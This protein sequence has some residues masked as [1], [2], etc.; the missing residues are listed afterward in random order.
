LFIT[1]KKLPHYFQAYTMIVLTSLPL[2]ALFRSS[3]FSGRISKWGAHLG[4]YDVRYR[5]RTSIKGQVLAD[6]VAKFAPEHSELPTME[7]HPRS[8]E[9]I[10]EKSWWTLYVDGAANSRGSGLGIVLM[11]PGGEMV[12]Q[13]V[14][15]GFGASNNEAE[16]EALLHGLRAAKRLGASFLNIRCDSQLI[17]NQLT[18][19]YMAKDER[20]MAYRD[21]AKGL[22][23]TFF[24][25]NIER[26]GREHNGHADS[27]AGI[28]SSVAPDFRR[29][30]TVEVQDSP[31][32]MKNSPAIICQI[33]TGP[34]WMDPILNYLTKDMLSAD[35]K[36]AAKIRR[37]ATRYLVSQEGKL[38]EKSY[39][40][41]YLLCVHPDL[42]PDLLYE[43]HEGVCGGHTGGRSLAHRAIEQGYWWPYM[44]KDAAQYVRRC[45]KCQ[46]FAPAIHKPAS[47]LNPISS[48]WPFAQWGLDL[49][50][51]LPRATGNRQ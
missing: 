11:S 3:D 14:R 18:G 37:D 44:Q 38:Y 33:E 25:F 36:E 42:V 16:Y 46:L 48:P 34:S 23:K 17:V 9:Q 51:P 20:M 43:I 28:A 5:P 10:T 15:L 2:K 24:E 39:T 50:G 31:S 19:E 8:A 21:L 35:Q 40:G 13:A 1:A 7:E 41:P 29:T 4:A 47:Q 32:I 45:E 30:I 6:F 27:L 12:E 49:V 26:V 22:L